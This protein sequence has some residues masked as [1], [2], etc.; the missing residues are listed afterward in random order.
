M[1]TAPNAAPLDAPSSPGSANGLRSRP[2]SAG[3]AQAERSAD[4][5][6]EQ[7][8][9]QTN[10]PED[11]VHE[12]GAAEAE[13]R[14][15]AVAADQQRGRR[16]RRSTSTPSPVARAQLRRRVPAVVALT[17]CAARCS[18][19]GGLEAARQSAGPQ[20]R[21]HGDGSLQRAEPTQRR[22]LEHR[23]RERRLRAAI[24]RQHDEL[25]RA[26]Q[27]RLHRQAAPAVEALLGRDVSQAGERR[28]ARGRA[29]RRRR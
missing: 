15:A 11:D 25:G 27:Q 13:R 17:G 4:E 14:A 5:H 23:V 12:L 8:P 16:P 2:C 19:R 1:M 10:L 9:R 29:S 28:A 26:A 24:S 7:R 3:A 6:G 21:R 20:R 22:M 18:K